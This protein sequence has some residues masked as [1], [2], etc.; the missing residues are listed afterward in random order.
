MRRTLIFILIISVTVA[1]EFDDVNNS[2]FSNPLSY[3][4][5][6]YNLSNRVADKFSIISNVGKDAKSYTKNLVYGKLNYNQ[7][8]LNAG[9][10][11]LEYPKFDFNSYE[12]PKTYNEYFLD[13]D[14][15][16]ESL[17]NISLYY[18]DGLQK[19]FDF[20][21][22]NIYNLIP[23]F[24]V[25]LDLNNSKEE[26]NAINYIAAKILNPI[27]ASKND[28]YHINLNYNNYNIFEEYQNG[29]FRFESSVINSFLFVNYKAISLGFNYQYYMDEKSAKTTYNPTISYNINNDL[30]FFIS[31]V[32]FNTKTN[33]YITSTEKQ[34]IISPVVNYSSSF[35]LLFT[36][37]SSDYT[38]SDLLHLE[39]RFLNLRKG[40]ILSKLEITF[41]SETDNISSRIIKNKLDAQ[42]YYSPIEDITLTTK[43]GTYFIE[44]KDINTNEIKTNGSLGITYSNNQNNE[45]RTMQ[46]IPSIISE[47]S[48]M[49]NLYLSLNSDFSEI[50]PFDNFFKLNLINP[51]LSER[52]YLFPIFYNSPKL[53]QLDFSFTYGISNN[54][55]ITPA[56]VLLNVKGTTY[57]RLSLEL[58]ILRK[59]TIFTIKYGL[60]ID[61][62]IGSKET[63]EASI[64][65]AFYF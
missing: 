9:Y 1:Q 62:A 55:S 36:E 6:F 28:H 34:E 26:L 54:I 3:Y 30:T 37:L 52:D 27:L 21:H 8:N 17:F 14:Y 47:N 61:N 51:D 32:L 48:V 41:F 16:Y 4:T 57:N 19:K 10:F 59:N 12:K 11:T 38:Y 29:T 5:K 39:K 2:Y 42:F 20:Q 45:I 60:Y 23:Q 56:N 46:N 64:K 18:H 53:T 40:D 43:V 7:F 63:H 35:G 44:L 24:T 49:L 50:N 22:K 31:S 25:S 65:L 33:N 15:R 58:D 13:L